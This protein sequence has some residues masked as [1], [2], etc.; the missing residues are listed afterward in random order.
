MLTDEDRA[1]RDLLVR[2]MC[3]AGLEAR[4]DAL[5]KIFD[6]LQGR[7]PELAPVMAGSHIDSQPTGGRFDRNDGVL[8]ALEVA[9]T[10]HAQASAPLRPNEVVIWTNEVGSR[11]TP[12][13]MGSG[14]YMGA[15]AL[16]EA[17]G[18]A[19]LR[20]F[21]VD[22]E[23]PPIGY[24]DSEPARPWCATDVGRLAPCPRPQ[25]DKHGV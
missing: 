6:R 19:D 11:F 13:M 21:T 14:V 2:W 18:S 20:G 9:R 7:Q 25:P 1:G 24:A 10:Q 22:A 23:L 3:A 16:R 5:G 4:V 15:I 12:V 17:M 8:A